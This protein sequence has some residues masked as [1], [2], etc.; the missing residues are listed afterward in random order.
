MGRHETGARRDLFAVAARDDIP[1][2]VRRRL[3]PLLESLL[4]E[5]ATPRTREAGNEQDHD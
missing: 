3:L 2:E 5:V 1:A 4:R